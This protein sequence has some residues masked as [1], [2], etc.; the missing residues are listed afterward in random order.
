MDCLIISGLSG[1]GKSLT[2]DVLE[3]IG[4]YC[5]DNMP[6]QLI[7]TFISLFSGTEQKYK[8]V[9]FVVDSRSNC[10][11][12]ALLADLDNLRKS[13]MSVRILFLDCADGVLVNRQKASRRRHPLEREDLPLASAIA[14]ERL[15]LSAMKERADFVLDTTGTAV[16]DFKNHLRSVFGENGG[17]SAMLITVNTFG[18]K[19]GMPYDSDLVF[20]VRCL[21]NPYY[22]PELRPLNGTDKRV[23]DYVM[24]DPASG[25]F[26]EK[27]VDMVSFLIPMY[28]KEG[29]TSLSISIG[30][31]GGK[32]R[33]V[34]MGCLLTEALCREGRQVFLRNRDMEK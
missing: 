15:Q 27:L 14:E 10:D 18:F 7:V 31:T 26:L 13:G 19:Y 12:Q 20:D 30:C 34:T 6:A 16:A 9:A 8:R 25:Q 11:Y 21:R 28:E 2:V 17:M 22:D 32:H 24:E 29:K 5:V 1:A 4:Y 3:D 33:S 23:Q